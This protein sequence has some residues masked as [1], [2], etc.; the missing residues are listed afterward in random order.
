M[1]ELKDKDIREA[2]R[3]REARRTKPELPADFCDSIMQEI[4]PRKDSRMRWRW[5]AAAAVIL[6]I[7]GIG[8]TLLRNQEGGTTDNGLLTGTEKRAAMPRELQPT[9]RDTVRMPATKS[10]TLTKPATHLAQSITPTRETEATEEMG[11]Q[12]QTVVHH[13]AATEPTLHYAAYTAEQD[14][15]YQDPAR[16]DEF[17][18]KMANYNK[19]KGVPLNCTTVRND[20]TVSGT[21]YVFEDKES[22]DVFGRLLQMACWYDSK[23]PGYMLNFSHQQLVFTLKDLHKQEKYFWMAERISG[24]RILLYCTHSPIETN[25]SPAC[26][27]KFR[28]QLT[29]TYFSSLQY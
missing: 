10:E 4:T 27:Q 15:N 16:M 26:Y 22:F 29:N 12:P 11:M 23:T 13:V 25:V 17:I 19:V 14:S 6:L 20:S 2:L 1:N 3:R 5:M 7:I 21:A 28:E 8:T 24:K 9:K 18:A